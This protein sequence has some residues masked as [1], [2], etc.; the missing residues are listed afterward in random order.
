MLK[1][2]GRVTKNEVR[3][4]DTNGEDKPH[5]RPEMALMKEFLSSV[6]E[7]DND[8]SK[9]VRLERERC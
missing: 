5:E 9:Q 7:D 1:L 6:V 2:C 4:T 3:D 8:L